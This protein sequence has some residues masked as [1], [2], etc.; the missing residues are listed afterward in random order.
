[1]TVTLE[2]RRQH[3]HTAPILLR[4]VDT[5]H[6]LRVTIDGSDGRTVNWHVLD[7]GPGPAGTIVCVHGN[8]S[9]GYVWKA[10]LTSLAPEWRVIAIDQTGMGWSE[11]DRPRLLADRVVELVTFCDQ[12]VAGPFVLAA[13]DWGGPVA[14]GASASLDVEALILCN[15]APK[16]GTTET[17]AERID[18]VTRGGIAA[19]AETVLSRWFTPTSVALTVAVPGIGNGAPWPVPRPCRSDAS[20]GQRCRSRSRTAC[21]RN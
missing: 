13:H 3:G 4:S 11:R 5:P 10:L 18:A 17:W 12:E 20:S 16:V 9:W 7:T 2:A 1:V 21:R 14:V 19:I 15:T 6:G 8:P